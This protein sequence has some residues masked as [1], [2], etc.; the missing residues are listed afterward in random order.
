MEM[1]DIMAL[2]L[3]AVMGIGVLIGIANDLLY[4]Q[5]SPAS[6]ANTTL[7]FANNTQTDITSYSIVPGSETVYGGSGE[8]LQVLKSGNY[9]MGYKGGTITPFNRT[10]NDWWNTS[11]YNISYQYYPAS[12]VENTTVRTIY[13]GILPLLAVLVLA[14][15]WYYLRV[16]D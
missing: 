12:Y 9:S 11:L 3:Y 14:G 6:V 10:E 7:T 8:G 15:I 4:T 1:K 2:I 5:Q 16:K 13:S